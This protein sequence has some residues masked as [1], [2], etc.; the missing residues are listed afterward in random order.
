MMAAEIQ[1]Q[2]PDEI[3]LKE[4]SRYEEVVKRT[5]LK[6]KEENLEKLETLKQFVLTKKQKHPNLNLTHPSVEKE[7]Q[8]LSFR[9]FNLIEKKIKNE[10]KSELEAKDQTIE[11]L[12]LQIEILQTYRR[13]F[14]RKLLSE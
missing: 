11:H 3:I 4:I 9:A 1:K 13:N 7:F 6:T 2:T 8:A 5:N 10:L 14:W 12:C